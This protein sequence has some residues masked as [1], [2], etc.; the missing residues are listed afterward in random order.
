MK[1]SKEVFSTEDQTIKYFC[2]F[3]KNQKIK[4]KAC[5]I[6]INDVDRNLNR[7][8]KTKLLLNKGSEMFSEN[9][10]APSTLPHFPLFSR[11]SLLNK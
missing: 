7:S 1:K 5:C 8:H 3:E 6:E 2:V 11:I 4:S 10:S 9:K